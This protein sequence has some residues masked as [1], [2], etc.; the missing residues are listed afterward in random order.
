MGTT[1][2]G[3]VPRDLLDPQG[4]L[5]LPARGFGD[6]LGAFPSLS[7]PC[8]PGTTRTLIRSRQ[9]HELPTPP[10]SCRDTGQCPREEL[11][12]CRE[13]VTSATNQPDGDTRRDANPEV[14]AELRLRYG[15]RR[16]HHPSPAPTGPPIRDRD[17]NGDK[18]GVAA[19]I[20]ENPGAGHVPG[21]PRLRVGLRNEPRVPAG[22]GEL[23]AV[24]CA[25]A[26][27][28]KHFIL[29]SN[30]IISA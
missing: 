27:N 23:L 19:P 25:Q 24:K 21:E 4:A 6:P 2:P 16:C 18:V 20:M 28:K 10:V 12:W 9:W 17:R 15:E 1:Q 3:G 11:P 5:R 7:S 14:T 8:A 30:C 26:L 29:F 22:R 13:Q